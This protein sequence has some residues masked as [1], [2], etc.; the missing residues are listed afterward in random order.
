MNLYTSAP[1]SAIFPKFNASQH[2]RSR[3]S[4][5]YKCAPQSNLESPKRSDLKIE[6]PFPRLL[7]QNH[8]CMCGR[9]Q[10]IEAAAA[11]SL[12]PLFPSMASSNPSSDY[13]DMLNRVHSPKP[14][15]Y[16]DFYASFLANSMK[17]YEEEIA[18]YKSQMFANLSGKAQK[19]LEIG[20][21]A[22]PNLKY[23]AGDEGVQVYGVDPN[24]KMEKYAREAAQNA[25]LPP[26][27][28][29]FK[30]AVG[31]AIP[32]PDASVDAVVGTL[33]LCS[34]TNVDMTLKE[35]K[36]VLR[37]G[38]L[39]IFVEHVAA[40]EGTMLRFMQNVLDPLQQI[41]F[42]GCHLIRTTGSNI[43]GAGFSNV[44]L[45]M[46][47]ISSFAFINPQVYGIAYR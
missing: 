40:K 28:F 26:E 18:D 29:V 14:E 36:R 9:R 25:G 41:A 47:S 8:S 35:V 23:Y 1:T 10:F 5:F 24:Q 12:L 32:L 33:V 16:E 7:C 19:V 2:V 30:Q 38:G 20:I 13:T 27:N 37:P 6:P 11:T 22:G 45:N 39:Y 43:M 15:W 34:V 17:S 46:T 4:S 21:G 3:S 31:E 44:D 42:D